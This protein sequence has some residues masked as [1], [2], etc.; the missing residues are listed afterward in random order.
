[1]SVEQNKAAVRR[2]KAEVFGKG[3]LTILPELFTSHYVLHWKT[4]D[5]K[6]LEGFKQY[7]TST[8][9]AFPDYWEKI[10]KMVGEQDMLATFY[11]RWG[12]VRGRIDRQ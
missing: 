3:N 2:L 5:L 12:C 6:G 10:E 4:I 7:H 8:K 11:T 1:M 9:K